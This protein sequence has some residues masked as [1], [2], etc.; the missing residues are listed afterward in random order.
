MMQYIIL[1]QKIVHCVCIGG[2]LYMCVYTHM[3]VGLNAVV[4]TAILLHSLKGMRPGE[5]RCVQC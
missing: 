4:G 5:G 2:S 1:L 3:L